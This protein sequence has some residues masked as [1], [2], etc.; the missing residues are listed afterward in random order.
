[1]KVKSISDQTISPINPALSPTKN[2]IA[3][4]TP[5]ERQV[6][7]T[8]RWLSYLLAYLY[9]Y[10]FFD[11]QPRLLL[12]FSAG[13]VALVEL[14][15]FFSTEKGFDKPNLESIIF[16]CSCLLQALALS[17]WDFRE[18]IEML[19]LLALHTSFVCYVLARNGW[20]AQGRIGILFWYDVLQGFILLPFKHFLL[21]LHFATFKEDKSEETGQSLARFRFILL[22][23]VSAILT[24]SLFTLF[25][26]SC[27]RY[28]KPSLWQLATSENGLTISFKV[29]FLA[30]ISTSFSDAL[31][32]LYPSVLGYSAW[33]LAACSIIRKN[34]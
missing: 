21:R 14:G 15:Q 5:A 23:T 16:A 19:Q 1:M 30:G 32:S 31:S 18:S 11:Y 8:G 27:R 9:I 25:G 12:L 6:F 17:I 29:C 33:W 26:N 24:F 10:I 34:H 13:M 28:R 2:R 4:L 3:Q 7:N 20:L 22:L